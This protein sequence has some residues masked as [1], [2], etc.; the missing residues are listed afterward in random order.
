[1]RAQR[2]REYVTLGERFL[3]GGDRVSAAAYFRNAVSADPSIALGYLSLGEVQIARGALRDAEETFR[4]GMQ[5]AEPD[6][7][8]WTGLARV[9]DA[10][11]RGEEADAMLSEGS[12]HFPRDENVM[13]LRRDRAESRLAWSL[14]LGLTRRLTQLGNERGDE[15]A[16]AE[17]A[18]HGRA[19]SVLVGELDPLAVDVEDAS[20]LRLALR[21]R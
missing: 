6:A 14:A 21:H 18:R 3:A 12:A 10:A 16:A 13:V 17:Y 7:R 19:L 15:V 1:M 5:R 2:A 8:M 4:A 9:L 11:H 20:P